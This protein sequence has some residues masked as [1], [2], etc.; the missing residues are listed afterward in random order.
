MKII[1]T[2]R[3]QNI[4]MKKI[5]TTIAFAVFGS[6]PLIAQHADHKDQDHQSMAAYN[7]SQL[8]DKMG[9]EN[10]LKLVL[11][12]EEDGHSA[13][14]GANKV[15]IQEALTMLYAR[16]ID[17]TKKAWLITDAQD[18]EKNDLLFPVESPVKTFLVPVKDRKVLEENILKLLQAT[19][20]K[21]AK[22]IFGRK[23]NTGW[24]K[25]DKAIILTTDTHFFYQT[26]PEKYTPYNEDDY[27][28]KTISA[29][30]VRH[31][32]Q[33][34]SAN[35]VEKAEEKEPASPA[36]IDRIN[37]Q[38]KIERVYTYKI[39]EQL[40]PAFEPPLVVDTTI[41]Y[42]S[43]VVTV[44]P[45]TLEEAANEAADAVA[46]AVRKKIDS[47]KYDTITRTKYINDS[48]SVKIRCLR[49]TEKEK[50]EKQ[51]NEKKRKEKNIEDALQK[52]IANWQS[53]VPS[54]QHTH[55]KR[56]LESTDDIMIHKV[57]TDRS[58]GSMFGFLSTLTMGS[59]F[60]E[61]E[62]RSSSS[63]SI[64]FNKGQVELSFAHNCCEEK[65]NPDA[66]F[67]K[68][69]SNFWPAE[70]G[71]GSLGRMR[72][73]IDMGQLATY[74]EKAEKRYGTVQTNSKKP[75][76]ADI[77]KF[78]D[79]EIALSI[80]SAEGR[81]EKPGPRLLLAV[82]L[83]DAAAAVAF[84]NKAA[85][86]SPKM[87]RSYQFDP[88]G[89]Y[90][91]FDSKYQNPYDSAQKITPATGS[92]PQLSFGNLGEVVIDVKKL[93]EAITSEVNK[94]D[95]FYK[96]VIDFFGKLE[97]NNLQT[98]DGKFIAVLRIDFGSNK[99]NSLASLA[100]FMHKNK[101]TSSLFRIFDIM[102]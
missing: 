39:P 58:L 97:M 91:L 101:K 80:S 41:S 96:E 90:L 95:D 49:L 44:N 24:I 4:V 51:I 66:N 38:G 63:T 48:L 72:F 29:D 5:C 20:H 34:I 61:S 74:F 13:K 67:Y 86:E 30:T 65:I 10:F 62:S 50:E 53:I 31:E 37:S 52:F 98:E 78:A 26:V 88:E 64:N 87:I 45:T 7:I 75:N 55:A 89:R 25:L 40:A 59:R 92:A 56:L 69:L 14:T 22:F 27:Y 32:F 54:P 8:A 93:L 84:M 1:F 19:S 83:K 73:N 15:A 35:P 21:K 47:K 99:T 3:I 77:V 70:L 76:P 36:E 42:D 46:E 81:H 9:A 2:F 57:R 82:K 16:G 94:E 100:E 71:D 60:Y 33:A 6:F 68:P 11:G 18:P 12:N 102:R 43:T 85:A 79:G 28:G 17:M 23:G